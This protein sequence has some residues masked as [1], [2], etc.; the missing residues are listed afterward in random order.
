[1]RLIKLRNR[2][3]QLW[4]RAAADAD[5]KTGIRAAGR[6]PPPPPPPPPE[7]CSGVNFPAVVKELD[8]KNAELQQSVDKLR[9]L[10]PADASLSE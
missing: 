7:T 4:R 10:S 3:S 2:V 8:R 6:R 5:Q 1:M 9:E